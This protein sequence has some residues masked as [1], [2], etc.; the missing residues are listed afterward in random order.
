MQKH[1]KIHGFAKFKLI[2]ILALMSSIAPLSTDMYLPALTHVE[3]SFQ[4]TTALTQLSLTSFFVAFALGQLIY[5]PISDIFGRKIPALIGIALFLTSSFACMIANS[6][7]AF[8]VLR[9]FE[10][11]GGCAGIVI[12]RAIVNDLFE[13]KEAAGIF[14]LMM[15]F[16]SIAPMLSPTF[17]GFLL[18]YFSWHSIFTTLFILGTILFFMIAFGLKESAPHLGKI[19][20]S[21][22]QTLQ[23]YIFVLK[24]KKF[25]VYI[26][27]A[28]FAMA[29]LFAYI[30]GS[31][32]V[33]TRV[34]NLSEQQYSALFGIN[35]LG[36]VTFAN[37]NARLVRKFDPEKILKNALL[38]M[39][40]C[41]CVLTLGAFIKG[42]F[43]LF[44]ISLFSCIALLGFIIPNTTTL[45]MARFK[46]HSG[47][48]SA[49]LGFVQFALA[50]L[51]SSL[52]GALDANTPLI[53]AF[54][55]C[56]CVLIANG[57]YFLAKHKA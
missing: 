50:G 39:L 44:E 24:D 9:F 56:A 53:L 8:I 48:A 36:F 41:A 10:A 16:S 20:F 54:V 57:V 49:V 17:G 35:A 11:L 28:G 43:W 1:T 52:V 3:Q 23:N 14:A 37:I 29:M 21:N 45:A 46:D 27:S 5:G 51:I 33:F 42:N 19:K 55:M 26:F 4:T 7:E 2:I 31:S 6:I 38:I 32:F 22:K 30:T 13:I 25:I 15:V 40:V 34:Y 47:T 12:A 18:E